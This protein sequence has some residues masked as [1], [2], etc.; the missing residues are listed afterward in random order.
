VF[1]V[2]CK[3]PEETYNGFLRSLSLHEANAVILCIETARQRLKKSEFESGTQLAK[4]RDKLLDYRRRGWDVPYHADP[5]DK[6]KI[7][8]LSKCKIELE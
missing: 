5:R 4:L 7:V 2:V 1:K 3:S 8:V 6:L